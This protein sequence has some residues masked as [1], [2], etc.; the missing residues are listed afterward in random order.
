MDGKKC[1]EIDY[2]VTGGAGFIGC[3]LATELTGGALADGDVSIVA[4]DCLHPQVHPDRSRPDALPR[5]VDFHEMDI[6]DGDAWDRV[7]A[8]LRPI[9]VVHLAAETGTGQSLE[10]PTRHTHVNVTGTAQM[11]EAFDR[12]NYRPQHIVLAS[13]RAVYGEG[14]WVDPVDNRI[15]RPG[16]RPVEQLERGE[17]AVIA[18][19]GRPARALPHDQ[20]AMSPNPVSVY[21]AT[22][23]A[24]EQIM[25]LWC[26]ARRV[27]LSILRFQNV[28][29][30][31][32]SPHNP[33]T[34]IVGLFHRVAAAGSSIEVYE[35][36]MIGRDFIY[37]DDV[38]RCITSALE[39]PPTSERILDVGRGEAT[40]IIDAARAIASLY[41]AP[42]PRIS[43]AFR[44]GDIRWAVAATDDLRSE[45]AFQ[46]QIGFEEGNR[47]LSEWLVDL[48][49]VAQK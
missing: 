26:L 36:G 33:Y 35:D 39:K 43:G 8:D 15:F 38:A 37:I 32:Q 6:C 47:R 29:G 49:Q 44:Y 4:A 14:R 23:L 7:L 34:G 48:G 28:Y 18:P 25:T 1:V 2:L 42:E 5:S 9:S 17:F 20:T 31:G 19:S 40:T 16:H 45:L 12:A 27:P 30:V 21:G 10:I 46:S 41:G 11:L 24:Q 13:S 3:A 22:K